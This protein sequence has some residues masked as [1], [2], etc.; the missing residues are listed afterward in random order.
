MYQT[1][2]H[3]GVSLYAEA[4]GLPLFREE[5]N[6][7][8][9]HHHKWYTPTEGDEVEDLYRLLARVKVIIRIFVKLGYWDYWEFHRFRGRYSRL[10]F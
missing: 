6:G 9:H 4:M 10:H 7:V 2:G 5:T 3:Q 8:A 1:V